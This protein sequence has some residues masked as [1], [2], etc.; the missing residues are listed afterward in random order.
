MPEKYRRMSNGHCSADVEFR[1]DASGVDPPNPELLK[2]HASLAQVLHL[3][4]AAKYVKS[5][6]KDTEDGAPLPTNPTE[7]FATRLRLA[8]LAH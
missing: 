6:Q 2:I 5:L 3:S 7:D 1:A 8:F 4:G